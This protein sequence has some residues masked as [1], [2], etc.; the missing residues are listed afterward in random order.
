MSRT[1]LFISHA[2]E[3]RDLTGAL[4]QLLEDA[5]RPANVDITCTSD[6]D[7]G[8]ERGA[9]LKEQIEQRLESAKALFLLATPASR[10]KDWVQFECAYAESIPDLKFYILVATS[11]RDESVPA[12]Y[13]ND[14]TVA[15]TSG[16][17]VLAF[18]KQLRRTFEI[19]EDGEYAYVPSLLDLVDR[20]T[21]LALERVD[22]AR[23]EQTDQHGAVVQR[24]RMWHMAGGLIASVL[25]LA[26]GLGIGQLRIA[27]LRTE[28][29][30]TLEAVRREMSDQN[31]RAEQARDAELK[32]LPFSGV[33]QDGLSHLV[34][35]TEVEARVPDGTGGMER[36]V[37]RQ[38]DDS[39]M[40]AFPGHELQADP[41][42]RILLKVIV[43]SRRYEL[44]VTRA[45]AR[46]ALA[47]PVVH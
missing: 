13:N 30:A 26:G 47:L 18:V 4:R 44:P 8:L 29:A 32:S 9:D 15:L 40:F 10:H 6:A 3:D 45:D 36:K 2:H 5:L 37:Q 22:A 23:R 19:V 35:C 11:S 42:E 16:A 28:H 27:D 46:L 34:R 17:D 1:G 14:V 43:G 31:L 21:A 38:C 25:A 41:R 12:P 33:F 7:Y 24:Q 39:G 20:C